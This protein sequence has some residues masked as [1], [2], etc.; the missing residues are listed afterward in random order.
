MSEQLKVY[1][2]TENGFSMTDD[3]VVVPAC[4]ISATSFLEASSILTK[5]LE[6]RKKPEC[7]E[8][9]TPIERINFE[10]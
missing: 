7:I 5:F 3:K 2:V 8:L 9:I 6:T 1:T 4:K 10:S